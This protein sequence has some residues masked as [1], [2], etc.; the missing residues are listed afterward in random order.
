MTKTTL[1][2]AAQAYRCEPCSLRQGTDVRELIRM[3]P[4]SLVIDGK[5]VG[6]EWYCCPVCYQPKFHC[7]TRKSVELM[8]SE[9]AER[10]PRSKTAKLSVVA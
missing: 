7:R 2:I 9:K 5:L 3:V 10:K 6:D 8:Q 4:L 1:S